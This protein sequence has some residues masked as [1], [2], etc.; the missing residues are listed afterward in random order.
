VT[1]KICADIGALPRYAP[2]DRACELL[3]FRRSKLYELAGDGLIRMIKVGSRSVVDMEAALA[4]M[5]TLPVA[6]IAPSQKRG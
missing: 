6:R 1:D 2:V 3:G 5:A 4:Y